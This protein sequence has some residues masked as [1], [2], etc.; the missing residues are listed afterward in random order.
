V[1]EPKELGV[2]LSEACAGARRQL[3]VCAPF[4]KAHALERVVQAT[5]ETVKIEVFTRWRP[6]EVAAGVSDTRVLAL[7]DDRG[8]SVYLCDRLHA[9]Y[10]RFD[11]RALVGS[12]N[13]TGAALGWSVNSN[14]EV[15]LEVAADLPELLRLEDSLRRESIPATRA[16]ADEVERVASLLPKRIV[17]EPDVVEDAATSLWSPQLREPRD[18]FVAYSHGLQRLAR[19]SAAAAA[20][21][22]SALE[23]P[24]G[25]D[26]PT[27]DALV[28]TRLL[29][30]PVM[31]R[32]DPVL[33]RPQRFGA[34]RDDLVR[35]LEIDRDEATLVWQT[36]M[37]W[38][39]Y[40]L[41]ERY[42]RLVPSHSELI[43]RAGI[44]SEES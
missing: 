20:V 3:V 35:V 37:R 19:V 24:A 5:N 40:F 28:A 21:D 33:S 30:A 16:L 17:I 44:E 42:R 29:Q 13:V 6:D 15:L 41:P 36:L 9:K 1:T 43:V 27:F 11:D 12:A 34:I 8:G 31:Q 14:L 38:L 22:L 25:L 10:F 39:L 32:V 18:L 4:I 23:L 26:E 7:V 2:V